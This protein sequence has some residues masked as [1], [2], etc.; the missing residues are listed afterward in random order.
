MFLSAGREFNVD[1]LI[2]LTL[3]L[4]VNIFIL[5]FLFAL[6]GPMYSSVPEFSTEQNKKPL[7]VGF[8][9]LDWD[10]S[11]LLPTLSG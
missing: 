9:F 2:A 7:N 1:F 10:P 8:G 5:K 11:C 3:T 4:V 6:S